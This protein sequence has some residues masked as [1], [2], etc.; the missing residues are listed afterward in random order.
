V[1]PSPS[2]LQA[3]VQ[4][5]G[6]NG[7]AIAGFVLALL[8]ALSSFIPIVNI[9]GDFLAFLG[10]IFGVIG[11]VQ[12]GKRVAG[13]ALSIAAIILAVAAFVIS[14][15]VNTATVSAVNDLR[16]GYGMPAR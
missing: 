13:K 7:L 1:E 5:T 4:T 9:G 10:L 15:V 2:S 11:L 14:I 6:S 3:P 12:S 16:P 8:G